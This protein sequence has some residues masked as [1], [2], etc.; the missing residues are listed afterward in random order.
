MLLVW[1]PLLA[2]SPLRAEPFLLFVFDGR[3]LGQIRCLPSLQASFP[4]SRSTPVPI[5]TARMQ[6]C[7]AEV[8]GESKICRATCGHR[9][10]LHGLCVTESRGALGVRCV[11]A[12]CLTNRPI[13]HENTRFER[14]A[15]RALRQW[16]ETTAQDRAEGTQH[17]RGGAC[18]SLRGAWWQPRGR[19]VLPLGAAPRSLRPIRGRLGRRVGGGVR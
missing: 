6:L 5:L 18:V 16:R 8:L 12:K 10:L 17:G 15:Q 1:P 4:P 2:W 3:P 9:P 13:V 14:R 7:E 19:G 11:T